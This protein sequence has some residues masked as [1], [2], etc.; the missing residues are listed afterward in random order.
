MPDHRHI[1]HLPHD[2]VAVDTLAATPRTV[3]VAV[4][5]QIAEHHRDSTIDGGVGDRHPNST[6]RTIVSAT[7]AAGDDIGSDTGL[8]G[9]QAARRRNLH[10][11]PTGARLSSATRPHQPGP[12]RNYLH[13]ISG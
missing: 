8:P 11:L 2:G 10:H 4:V 6:V 9:R 13:S 3:P 5:E 7:T 1:G 12:P